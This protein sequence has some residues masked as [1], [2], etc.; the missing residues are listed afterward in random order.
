MLSSFS[1]GVQDIQP[2][3]LKHPRAFDF[4]FQL[5]SFVSSAAG[6]VLMPVYKSSLNYVNF[7]PIYHRSLILMF[8]ANDDRKMNDI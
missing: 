1:Q 7:C 5:F 2:N 8:T 4:S 3:Y 6:F